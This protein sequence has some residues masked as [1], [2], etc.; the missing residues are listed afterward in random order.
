MGKVKIDGHK[1]NEAKIAAKEIVKSVET[2]YDSCE[3]LISYVHAAKWSGK[4]RDSFI[5][6]MEIIQAY[7]KDLKSAVAKQ[8]KALNNLD[9]YMDDYQRDSAVREVRNL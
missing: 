7:H 5:S 4:S 6:Y 1:V 8:T 2:T 3:K 9:G